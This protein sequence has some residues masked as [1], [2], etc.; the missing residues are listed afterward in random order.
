MISPNTLV[1]QTCRVRAES[2]RVFEVL[3][4][5]LE[6]ICLNLHNIQ[7]NLHF[8]QSKAEVSELDT[9]DLFMI[10]KRDDLGVK[11]LTL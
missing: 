10:V 9:D 3:E 4:D 11:Y 8:W 5:I 2:S 7:K 6:H 1:L